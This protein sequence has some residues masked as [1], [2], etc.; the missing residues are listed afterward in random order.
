MQKDS[1]FDREAKLTNAFETNE[2]KGNGGV[3]IFLA[4]L[5]SLY[6]VCKRIYVGKI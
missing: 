2:N 5:P 1:Q 6:L 4:F 3:L